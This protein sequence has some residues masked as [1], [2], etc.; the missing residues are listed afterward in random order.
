MTA[1]D[2]PVTT[3]VGPSHRA[4]IPKL[5]NHKSLV[6]KMTAMTGVTALNTHQETTR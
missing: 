6:S 2:S 5:I 1:H 3:A 4:V